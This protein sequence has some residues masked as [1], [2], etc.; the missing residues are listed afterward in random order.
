VWLPAAAPLAVFGELQAVGVIAAILGRRVVAPL[1]LIAGQ[2]NDD[3]IFLRLLGHVS[4]QVS[5]DG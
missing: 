3:A 2:V 1:A 4:S 5:G